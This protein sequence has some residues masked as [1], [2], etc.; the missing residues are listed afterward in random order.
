[1]APGT[2]N[3]FLDM[4]DNVYRERSVAEMD[5]IDRKDSWVRA[6]SRDLHFCMLTGEEARIKLRNKCTYIFVWDGG[7]N[8][9][10][11]PSFLRLG[12]DLCMSWWGV[13]G[14]ISRQ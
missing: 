5:L 7:Q 4:L 2:N 6:I 8:V 10:P 1:M 14:N 13:A 3:K 11:T 12:G 9:S